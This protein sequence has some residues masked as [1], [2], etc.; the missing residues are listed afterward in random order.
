MSIKSQIQHL[1]KV[2]GTAGFV[3]ISAP[4]WCWTWRKLGK[5]A[6]GQKVV[7]FSSLPLS[8]FLSLHSLP[9]HRRNGSWLPNPAEREPQPDEVR[10]FSGLIGS[11]LF[12]H[13]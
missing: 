4:C 12:I 3:R 6:F 1:N 11:S 9:F 2:T 5:H 10:N 7:F 13:C 8:S